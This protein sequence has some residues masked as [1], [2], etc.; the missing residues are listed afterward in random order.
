[1]EVWAYIQTKLQTG[2]GV[3]LLWVLDSEGSS[4]GRK[5]FRMAI[6]ADGSLCGTIGGGI[7]EHKLVELARSQFS[8]PPQA[9]VLIRQYHDRR[10]A[11]DRSGM[12]CS[13]SQVIVLVDL[14]TDAIPTIDDLL[15]SRAS[16]VELSPNGVGV[17]PNAIPA[18]RFETE[19]NWTYTERVDQR[20]RV[21]IVGGGH[22]SLALSELLHF[23]GYSITLYDNRPGLNTIEQNGFAAEKLIIDYAVIGEHI[24]GGANDAVV[25]MTFGYRDDKI[26]FRQLL[27]KPFFY[28]GMMGS[29][30][31]VATLFSELEAEGVGPTLWKDWSIPIGLPIFSKT[32]KEI[33]VSIAG[34]LIREKNK[35]L[36][37]GRTKTDH[38]HEA[39]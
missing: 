8:R 38:P 25:I 1:M 17:L 22:V 10:H 28:A 9:P 34:E 30:Q 29:E 3:K 15:S 32:A 5:G 21:H 27:G 12:I 6:G 18:F 26:A 4:P 39:S 37:T 36:P 14:T 16:F 24:T 20:I 23:L 33:A 2:I 11:Q 13:G 35:H 7:M 31:K 19:T